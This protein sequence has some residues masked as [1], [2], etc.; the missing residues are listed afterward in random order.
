MIQNSNLF[1]AEVVEVGA[2]GGLE[3]AGEGGAGVDE[4]GGGD[5]G[6]HGGLGGLLLRPRLVGDADDDED[7][8]DDDDDPA[9]GDDVDQHVV[10]TIDEA[11]VTSS[12]ATTVTACTTA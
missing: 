12:E 4:G 1:P 10:D 5:L 2:V 9:P 11:S 6:D 7:E 8:D 3:D